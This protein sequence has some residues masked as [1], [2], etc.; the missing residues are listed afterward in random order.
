MLVWFLGL[1]L[2]PFVIL[3]SSTVFLDRPLYY[4]DVF[5][6]HSNDNTV[7]KY[8][9]SGKKIWSLNYSNIVKKQAIFNQLFLLSELGDL[10]V[11][12]SKTGY[13]KWEQTGAN[14]VSFSIHFPFIFCWANKQLFCFDF[15]SGQELWNYKNSSNIYQVLSLGH[16]G[17]LIL[18]DQSSTLL[19]LDITTGKKLESH[20]LKDPKTELVTSWNDGFLFKNEHFYSVFNN[21]TKT[22]HNLDILSNSL[23]AIRHRYHLIYFD[24]QK[25]SLISFNLSSLTQTWSIATSNI[26]QVSNYQDTLMIYDESKAYLL[27]ANRANIVNSFVLPEI[28]Y[29]DPITG[30]TIFDDQLYL[31]FTY[32]F[33]T[34][35]SL[36]IHEK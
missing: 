6:S 35:V 7:N 29:T 32:Q 17:N 10:Y 30:F 33:P 25:D 3:A 13:L 9:L 4:E 11:I 1:L 34:V 21:N 20:E 36:N 16:S 5:F 14:I 18:K 27:D 19:F 31:H 23:H 15:S 12:D 24:D 22:F 26:K 8:Q 2:F 28:S